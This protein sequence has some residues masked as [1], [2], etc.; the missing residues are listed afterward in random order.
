MRGIVGTETVQIGSK[1]LTGSKDAYGNP[2]T[3]ATFKTV[4]GVLVAPGAYSTDVAADG[5]ET[6]KV[7][8]FYLPVSTAIEFKNVIIYNGETYTLIS[9]PTKWVVPKGSPLKTKIVAIGQVTFL[10]EEYG[11]QDPA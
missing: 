2:L 7:A 8:T 1:A 5:Y 6:D 11:I 9:E 10:G 3:V 4:T